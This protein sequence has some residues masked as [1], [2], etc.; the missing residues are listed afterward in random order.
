MT[1]FSNNVVWVAPGSSGFAM[2]HV[3]IREVPYFGLGL[4]NIV[5]GGGKGVGGGAPPA[6]RDAATQQALKGHAFRSANWT[7]GSL[8]IGATVWLMGSNAEV[9]DCDLTCTKWCIKVSNDAPWFPL[10][11]DAA[12]LT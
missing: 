10:G 5:P 8:A 6:V 11:G 7:W 1:H 4:G 3:L 9:T 12:T 2:R